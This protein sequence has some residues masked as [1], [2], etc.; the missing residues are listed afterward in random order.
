MVSGSGLRVQWM[1]AGYYPGAD[2]L[3]GQDILLLG[4]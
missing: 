2:R 1:S 3:T 4:L